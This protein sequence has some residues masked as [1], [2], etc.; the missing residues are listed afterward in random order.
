MSAEVS[1]VLVAH[2][3]S[4]VA[5][6]AVASFR[7]EAGRL[8]VRCEVVIVDHSEDAGECGRLR[9]LAPERL[10]AL[11]NRGYAAGV[12][13]GIAASTGAVVLVATPTYAWPGVPWGRCSR[14]W[15]AAGGSSGRSS[16]LRVFSC[17]PRTCRRPARRFGAGWRADHARS[18]IGTSGTRSDGGDGP[19]RPP[20][21]LP[22]PTSRGR[23]SVSGAR[24]RRRLGPW[25]E[26]YFLYFE[27]TD[28]LRRAASAGA[29][30]RAG[31]G[32]S[33]R[34]PVG[35]CGGSPRHGEPSP[36]LAEPLPPRAFRSEWD[37]SSTR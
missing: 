19:G 31:A 29:A 10:L 15:G 33:G 5:P 9:S 28:W 24:W 16:S 20:R 3:S 13:A 12:N 32:G 26:G 21:R 4:A 17:R 8:G 1:L 6:A 11:P 7:D 18:G 25:D 35:S 34:A 37:E 27:E 14:R 23:W 36:A 22:C 30:D 2:F